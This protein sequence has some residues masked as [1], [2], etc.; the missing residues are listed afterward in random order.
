LQIKHK[1]SE[2]PI[3]FWENVGMQGCLN[4]EKLM[5]CC[6]VWTFKCWNFGDFSVE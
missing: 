4:V 2:T 1:E 5:K 3:C 6:K